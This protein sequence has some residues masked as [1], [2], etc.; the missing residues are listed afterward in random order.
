MTEVLQTWD[1]IYQGYLVSASGFNTG[2]D[3]IIVFSNTDSWAPDFYRVGV[4]V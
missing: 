3:N 1:A 4:S 2:T